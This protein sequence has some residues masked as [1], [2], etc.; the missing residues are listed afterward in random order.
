MLLNL[1]GRRTTRFRA[2]WRPWRRAVITAVGPSRVFP[3][4]RQRG[5]A[6]QCRSCIPR[7]ARL[8]GIRKPPVSVAV[9]RLR[10]VINARTNHAPVGPGCQAPGGRSGN[11]RSAT[12][13]PALNRR[14]SVQ[15]PLGAPRMPI[16]RSRSA[17]YSSLF[18]APTMRTYTVPPF[19]NPRKACFQPLRSGSASDT[20]DRRA[21]SPSLVCCHSYRCCA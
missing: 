7:A 3:V 4:A 5:V 9:S 16:I 1:T 17:K 8:R 14:H 18:I 21:I 2:R 10:G 19:G 12:A 15:R 6:G 20:Q 13:R 11:Y